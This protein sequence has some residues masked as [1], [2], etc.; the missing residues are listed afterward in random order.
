MC[1]LALFFRTVEDAPVV[2]GANREEAYGRGG[3][4]PLTLAS[5]SDPSAASAT[6]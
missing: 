2:A 1:L 6:S 3:T 5:A 4:P